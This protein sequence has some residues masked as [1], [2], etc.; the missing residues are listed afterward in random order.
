MSDIDIISNP[1]HDNGYRAKMN[2]DECRRFHES[3]PKYSQTPLVNLDE[4]SK[5]LN[6]K[7]IQIKDESKRFGLNAFKSLG[8]SYAMAKIIVSNVNNEIKPQI[9]SKEFRW[10]SSIS[11]NLLSSALS[12]ENSSKNS[13]FLLCAMSNIIFNSEY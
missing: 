7:S 11:D 13:S 1:F 4:F 6:L 12:V 5:Q 9:L 3:L 10:R 8:A 2:S